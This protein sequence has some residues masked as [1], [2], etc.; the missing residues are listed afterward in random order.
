MNPN[1]KFFWLGY[2]LGLVLTIGLGGSLFY[3]KFL[4]QPAIRLADMGLVDLQNR[5][6]AST[7]WQGQSVV[8]NYWATWCGPCIAEF[9][10]F[11]QAA[12]RAGKRVAFVMVSDEPAATIQAFTRKH[13]YSFTFLRVRQPLPGVNVRPVTYGYSKDKELRE[14]HSGSVTA[15]RL[16][17]LI[18]NL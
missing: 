4:Y 18:D 3:Y 5:P 16:A 14:K 8:V 2:V 13:A 12:Q 15:T 9:P 17:A 7:Q 1:R 10:L 11:E 6:V